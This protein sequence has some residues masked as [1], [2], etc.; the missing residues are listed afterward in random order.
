MWED[1]CFKLGVVRQTPVPA[2]AAVAAAGSAFGNG[3]LAMKRH[4]ALAAVP[5]AG[6]NFDFVDEHYC[7]D[8][9]RTEKK[10]RN[11]FPV[12]AVRSAISG[13]DEGAGEARRN[14]KGEVRDLAVN[15]DQRYGQLFAVLLAAGTMFT[16]RLFLSKATLPSTRA[17]KVQS[18]PVPTLLP[19]K[20]LVPRW[21]TMMLPAVTNSPPKHFTPNR[22]L[23]LS[24]P[25][26]TLPCPFL[27]AILYALISAIL[28]RVSSCRCPT[29]RW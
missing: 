12:S 16:R 13:S 18:R 11:I 23:T 9:N 10:R 22:F 7:D 1:E 21:R 17:N 26:R 14:K 19:A 5:G 4:A 27:C 15:H 8:F 3:G 25:L 24:R 29:V 20:N 6:E 2:T 28:T